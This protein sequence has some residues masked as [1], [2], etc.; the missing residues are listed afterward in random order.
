MKAAGFALE[1]CFLVGMAATVG[2]RTTSVVPPSAGELT[3]LRHG[4]KTLVLLQVQAESGTAE[5]ARGI[6]GAI[7]SIDRDALPE[8]FGSLPAPTPELGRAGWCA[9]MLE[10]GNY[11]LL[12]EPEPPGS[13]SLPGEVTETHVAAESCFRYPLSDRPPGCA[14]RL[15]LEVPKGARVVYAGSLR[16][17]FRLLEKAVA[18]SFKP[19]PAKWSWEALD[20]TV[21]EAGA[22]NAAQGI[23]GAAEPV[24]VRPVRFGASGDLPSCRA[25]GVT[26]VAGGEPA[27]LLQPGWVG[28]GMGRATGSHTSFPRVCGKRMKSTDRNALLSYNGGGCGLEVFYLAYLP[29]GMVFGAASGGAKAS[30]MAAVSREFLAEFHR[31]QP[32]EALIRSLR[33]KQ[34]PPPVP[35]SAAP[36]PGLVCEVSLVRAEL[37]ECAPRGNFCLELAARFAWRRADSGELVAER[38]YSSTH[39]SSL[40]PGSDQVPDRAYETVVFASPSH[41]IADLAKAGGEKLLVADVPAMLDRLAEAAAADQPGS[42]ELRAE[43]TAPAALPAV[44]AP[45]PTTQ[46]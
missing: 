1:V 4:E 11:F 22:R 18:C 9:W 34:P 7:A 14:T 44:S 6:S 38:V 21:D 46:P 10:P 25:A 12:I 29:V 33:A 17:R 19:R 43:A 27:T 5:P 26:Y 42:A 2:C 13:W 39:P 15:W 36:Q 40:I 32:A 23:L 8:A 24:T 37:N 16:W 28:R 20:L 3:A 31:L 41:P 35:S 30:A 45:A